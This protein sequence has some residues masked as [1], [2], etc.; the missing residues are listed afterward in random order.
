MN[1]FKGKGRDRYVYNS[2]KLFL[3]I[4]DRNGVWREYSWRFV[5]TGEQLGASLILLTQGALGNIYV[6]N[7]GSNAF[8]TPTG[9]MSL[10]ALGFASV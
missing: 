9:G 2:K 4:R 5:G 3:S 6:N 7:E 10:I 1:N 8:R